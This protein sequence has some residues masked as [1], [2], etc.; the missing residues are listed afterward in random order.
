MTILTVD[1]LTPELK[2]LY[3]DLPD[4]L[5]PYLL[6]LP[7]RITMK[8]STAFVG[9]SRGYIYDQAALGNV[10]IYKAGEKQNSLI[11]VGTVS[12]LKLMARMRLAVIKPRRRCSA[13]SRP[14]NAT[15]TAEIAAK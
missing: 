13:E 14:Q 7:P 4:D 6:S 10:D 2:S 9:C 1:Q 5:R 12:L 15:P 8:R 3:D 11:L